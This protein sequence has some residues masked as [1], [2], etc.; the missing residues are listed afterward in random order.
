[1][2]TEQELRAKLRKIAALFEGATTPG[3]REAAAAAIR[4]VRAA[5]SEAERAEKAVEMNFRL[6]D[7][8]NRR[9]FTALCR[10]YGLTPYRYP[11][12]R[13]ST[14]VLRAPASFINGTLWPEFLEIKSALDEYLNEATE[15]IIREEVFGNSE[16]AEE[17]HGS[18]ANSVDSADHD[19]S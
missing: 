11:R 8:W 4:R 12:Q 19:L 14:V 5:L 1:L 6:P 2:T 10:R 7:R 17:R 16:E 13:Y 9:L 18:P 3:E 15:R